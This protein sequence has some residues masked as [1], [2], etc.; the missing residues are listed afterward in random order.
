MNLERLCFGAALTI[1]VGFCIRCGADD[2]ESNPETRLAAAPACDASERSI[3]ARQRFVLDGPSLRVLTS[4]ETVEASQVRAAFD[5]VALYDV[6]DPGNPQSVGSQDLGFDALAMA[7][8]GARLAVSACDG[9][10][11]FDTTDALAP[12][13]GG[14]MAFRVSQPSELAMQ[15]LHAIGLNVH[16]E[17]D[18]ALDI[19]D[20]RDPATPTQAGAVTVKDFWQLAIDGDTW[21]VCDGYE[22]VI[23]NVA[24]PAS[25]AESQR[26]S[27]ASKGPCMA[28]GAKGGIAVAAFGDTL[29]V[30]NTTVSPAIE[31]SQ[32]PISL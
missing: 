18:Y 5:R 14:I 20:T 13:R 7:G 1:L 2:D 9:T 17:A 31:L 10:Y 15:G 12:V 3:G 27:T 8:S 26:L 32:L 19:V 23:L 4:A 22:L 6:T 28:V 25:P 30:L 16:G 21:A 29:Q 11:V 24:N